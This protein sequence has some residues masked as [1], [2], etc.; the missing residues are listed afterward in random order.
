MRIEFY[1]LSFNI[2]NFDVDKVTT[3]NC[4]LCNEVI[5]PKGHR[6]GT[7]CVK[8]GDLILAGKIPILTGVRE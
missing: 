1:T 5:A 8:C 4:S 2:I 6:P 3:W 7:V